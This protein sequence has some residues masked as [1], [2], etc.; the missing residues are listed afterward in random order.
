MQVVKIKTLAN[1]PDVS[2]TEPFTNV[3]DA[4]AKIIK[5]KTAKILIND[6]FAKYK[7][8]TK[9]RKSETVKFNNVI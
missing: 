5:T 9:V 7:E 8:C 3:A 6:I 2:F 1:A 4:C